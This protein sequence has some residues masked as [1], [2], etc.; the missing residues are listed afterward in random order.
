MK[1]R[2]YYVSYSWTGP[3]GG[4]FGSIEVSRQF[5]IRGVEDVDEIRNL[6]ISSSTT[7]VVVISWQRFE[8]D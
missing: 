1:W 6:I 8:E 5:P 3:S 2:K 4:G 7:S